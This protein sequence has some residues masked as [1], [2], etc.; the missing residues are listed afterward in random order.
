MFAIF[1]PVYVFLFLPIFA[2]LGRDTD[3]FLERTAKLQWGL[4]I[5]VYCVSHVPA[6]LML[7]IPGY[8]GR[9]ALLLFFLRSVHTVPIAAAGAF[10]PLL[11]W[12]ATRWLPPLA[13]ARRE[14]L[15]VGLALV[16]AAGTFAVVNTKILGQPRVALNHES[17]RFLLGAVAPL[18]AG[19]EHLIP[20][21]PERIATLSS[22]DRSLRLAH[23]FA[24]NG[25]VEQLR[26]EHGAAGDAGHGVSSG[27]G[28]CGRGS[29]PGPRP[30]RGARPGAPR[31]DAAAAPG[32]HGRRGPNGRGSW[33]RARS[34][35]TAAR[36]FF[37]GG[38]ATRSWP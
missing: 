20:L 11:C 32:P 35:R 37:R 30:P 34:A 28:R 4:A 13:V 1:I 22:F 26:A 24:P 18:L 19:Q 33:Q 14:A 27:P 38:P 5:A 7:D 16:A 8:D 31:P 36:Y 9:N 23:T 2:A 15:A 3:R 17:S 21:P 12:V 6:L 10:Y 25:V 29:R